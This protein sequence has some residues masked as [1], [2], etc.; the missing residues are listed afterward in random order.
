MSS[1]S[2][3]EGEITPLRRVTSTTVGQYRD[4]VEYRCTLPPTTPYSPFTTDGPK[5]S[6]TGNIVIY[7]ILDNDRTES[8]HLLSSLNPWI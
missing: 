3:N 4:R 7:V 1:R 6:H 2:H 5:D 8:S